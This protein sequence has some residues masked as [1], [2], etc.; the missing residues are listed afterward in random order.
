M[1]AGKK[2]LSFLVGI[3]PRRTIWDT[4]HVECNVPHDKCTRI[5][6]HCI[7]TNG[8]ILMDSEHGYTQ[9]YSG[10]NGCVVLKMSHGQVTA[11][12]LLFSGRRYP[13][14]H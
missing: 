10:A 2:I 14:T 1:A 13:L 12:T 5:D 11:H 6:A 3:K 7:Y 9:I 8:S 4:T